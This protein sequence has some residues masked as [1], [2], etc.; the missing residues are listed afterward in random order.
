LR[1]REALEG[2]GEHADNYGGLVLVEQKL[3]PRPHPV[4]ERQRAA[5][6]GVVP[7]DRPELAV[8]QAFVDPSMIFLGD[9]HSELEVEWRV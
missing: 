8:V 3:P 1:V 2:E 9:H 5:R 4:A 6:R 7:V